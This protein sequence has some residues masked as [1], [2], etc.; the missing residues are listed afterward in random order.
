MGWVLERLAGWPRQGHVGGRLG[1]NH[2]PGLSPPSPPLLLSSPPPAE[3]DR[4]GEVNEV[5]RRRQQRLGALALHAPAVGSLPARRPVPHSSRFSSPHPW[6]QNRRS[7]SASCA[8][9]RSSA[10]EGGASRPASQLAPHAA[11][12][13]T[14]R[15]RAEL[16]AAA[17]S[18]SQRASAPPPSLPCLPAITCFAAGPSSVKPT[19]PSSEA[20]WG[21]PAGAG[22]AGRLLAVGA[23][24]GESK[25]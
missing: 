23:G 6:P 2:P 15:P 25:G 18:A 24:A 17:A 9:P 20:S 13:D 1:P 10:E 22:Q 11:G 8:R 4:D 7:S 21:S 12:G 3:A 16:E 19:A 5:R 14:G